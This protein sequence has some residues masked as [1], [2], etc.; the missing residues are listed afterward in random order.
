V[1][2]I[3]SD[4]ASARAW[5][6]EHRLPESDV[7]ALSVKKRLFFQRPTHGHIWMTPM[8]LVL[9][10]G[11]EVRDARPWDGSLDVEIL[12]ELCLSGGIAPESVDEY[13]QL[14]ER[15]GS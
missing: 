8:R 1:W 5:A 4:T 13:L 15:A 12:E 9:T 10:P 3:L 7:F 2:F 11:L 14:L 6:R